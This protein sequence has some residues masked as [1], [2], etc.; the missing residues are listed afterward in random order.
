MNKRLQ[1]RLKN[2]NAKKMRR[3]LPTRNAD[4]LEVLLKIEEARKKGEKV[5]K[6]LAGEPKLLKELENRDFTVKDTG[7]VWH[8]SW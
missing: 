1:E 7:K 4:I 3:A 6:I 8:I 2:L 5:C